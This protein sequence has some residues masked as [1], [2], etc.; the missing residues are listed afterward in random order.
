VLNRTAMTRV[1]PTVARAI[2]R[3]LRPQRPAAAPHNAN[4]KWRR[5]CSRCSAASSPA[6]PLPALCA[7]VGWTPIKSLAVQIWRFC[8]STSRSIWPVWSSGPRGRNPAACDRLT[9][10]TQP[11]SGRPRHGLA[12]L[13]PPDGGRGPAGR[14]RAPAAWRRGF[15]V[16]VRWDGVWSPVSPLFQPG[17]ISRPRPAWRSAACNWLVTHVS[18]FRV[19]STAEKPSAHAEAIVI[20]A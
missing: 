1:G 18:R 9:C 14:A 10:A 2:R 4:G 12:C 17:K 15:C 11:P 6:C 7:D 19:S 20:A 13:S 5:T 8:A 3:A 16:R